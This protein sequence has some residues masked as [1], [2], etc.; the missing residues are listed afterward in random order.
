MFQSYYT[1]SDEIVEFMVDRLEIHSVSSILEP[2][3]GEGVFVKSILGKNSDLAITM[4]EINPDA[5]AHLNKIFNDL[6]NVTLFAEDAIIGTNMLNDIKSGTKYDRIICN[7]PYGAWQ[8]FTR[9]KLLKKEFDGLY[10]KDTYALFIYRSIQLLCEGG[11]GVFIVPDTFLNV[12]MHTKLRNYIFRNTS[13]LEITKFPSSFFPGI[14]FGYSNLCII[15]LKKTKSE[16]ARNQNKITINTN[17]KSKRDFSKI[18]KKDYCKKTMYQITQESV[19]NN[20][21]HAL[22]ITSAEV[23]N[24]INFPSKRIGDL[25]NCVTGF[26][27]GNDKKYLRPISN[28]LKNAKKYNLINI[29]EVCETTPTSTQHYDGIIGNRNYVPIMKGGNVRFFKPNLWY[30]NWSCESVSHYKQDSKS[31]FQNPSYYF[32]QGIGIPMV[33]TNISAALIDN[34]LFD[35]SI[36]GVFPHD[37]KLVWFLLAFFN[38]STCNKLLKVINPTA[39]N[40]ANYIKK[41]PIIIPRKE[42][43]AEIQDI[44][45]SAYEDAKKNAQSVNHIEKLDNLFTKIYGF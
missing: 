23:M 29:N 41:L 43:L 19:F 27:S 38:S 8:D 25:A 24:H 32:K 28:Q 4:Y 40:S 15:K 35:Q 39:N 17:L 21:E 33:G 42:T 31:R 22:F 2:C 45:I 16:T 30:M 7:P 37:P 5:V 20:L 18:M 3:A 1:Q 36:V 34:R 9:R 44:S 10:V 13:I 6:E 11:I 26:Y 14:Q 12:H